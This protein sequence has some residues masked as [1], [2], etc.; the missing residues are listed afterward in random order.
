[1]QRALRALMTTLDRLVPPRACRRDGEL[2]A[3]WFKHPPI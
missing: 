2:P 1:M 3:E